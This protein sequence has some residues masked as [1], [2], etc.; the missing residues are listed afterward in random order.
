M[1]NID[2]RTSEHRVREF[3]MSSKNVLLNRDEF[4]Q[5][6]IS[7]LMPRQYV[8]CYSHGDVQDLIA[9]PLWL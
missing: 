3:Q 9:P 7:H 6:L 1:D 5:F 4:V 8:Y 2:K